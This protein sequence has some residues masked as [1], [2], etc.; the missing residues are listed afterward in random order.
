VRSPNLLRFLL[1]N[2]LYG[3]GVQTAVAMASI[4]AATILGWAPE[5]LVL[6]F[7][8]VQGTALVGSPILGRW[9]DRWGDRAVLLGCLC[10]WILI[11]VATWQL[12]WT[13][14][15]ATEYWTLGFLAGFVLGPTQS[16]S[17]SLLGRWAP[18][19]A[20]GSVFSLFAVS[21]RFAAIF[22]PL[23][24]GLAAWATNDLRAAVL[25]MALFFAAGAVFLVSVRVVSLREELSRLS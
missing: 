8:V 22:G 20:S 2:L 6:Y 13:G 18:P 19:S 25:T 17:R 16:L 12:G 14:S 10:V 21:N 23:T 4:F 15:P 1:A 9:A 7:L 3:D 5:R 24:Y 11:A